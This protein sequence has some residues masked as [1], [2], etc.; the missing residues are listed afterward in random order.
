MGAPYQWSSNITKRCHITHVKN[1]YR[2]SNRCDFH[3]QCCCFLDQ[4][5]KQCFFHVFTTLKTAGASLIN[6]MAY[7]ADLMQLHYPELTWISTISPDPDE[8]LMGQVAPSKSVFNNPHSQILSDCTTALLLTIQPR[9]PGLSIDDACHTLLIAGFRKALGNF[10]SG[11][12]CTARN[13]H[14]LA[15]HNCTLLF[16]H[17]HAWDKFHIQQHSAHKPLSLHPAQ[18]VQALPSTPALPFCH[19][20]TILISHESGNLIS[21]E[22][23]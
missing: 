15:T 1:A 7:K 5:E 10:F 20:N 9:F 17:I 8:H 23:N 11:H 14:H 18:T 12:S 6:E 3:T 22:S 4:Q 16:P 19:V 2:L 21:A 13:D